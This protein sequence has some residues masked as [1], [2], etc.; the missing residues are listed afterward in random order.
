MSM[1][2]VY[3]DGKAVCVDSRHEV[4]DRSTR[5]RYLCK[6]CGKR[7]STIETYIQVVVDAPEN[8]S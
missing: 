7:W 3:C 6:M 2:C 5:R 4:S 1:P 8:K